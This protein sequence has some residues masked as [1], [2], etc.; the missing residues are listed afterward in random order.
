METLENFQKDKSEVVQSPKDEILDGVIIQFQRG[1]LKEFLKPEV[2]PKFD[3]LDQETLVLHF[4]TRFNDKIIKGT[5]RMPYYE[6]PMSNSK[7]GKFLNK[8]DKMIIGAKVKIMYDGD[9]FGHIK[10]D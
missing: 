8:Y 6:E 2:H 7:M 5:D 4:E 9:G 1:K 3:N 10:L